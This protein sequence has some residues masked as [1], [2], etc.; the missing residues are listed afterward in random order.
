[1]MTIVPYDD[2]NSRFPPNEQWDVVGSIT[3]QIGNTA[4]RHGWKIIEIY[5]EDNTIG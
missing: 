5:E 2:Y 1:M 3:L 4:R